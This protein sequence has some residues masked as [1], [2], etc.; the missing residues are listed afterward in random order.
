MGMC[1]TCIGMGEGPAEGNSALG[2]GEPAFSGNGAMCL[3]PDCM[4]SGEREGILD[5]LFGGYFDD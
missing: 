3:C 2:I 4:G 1:W 5:G